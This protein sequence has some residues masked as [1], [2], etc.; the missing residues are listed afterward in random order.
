MLGL[1]FF[2]SK[3]IKIIFLE[4]KLFLR[5]AYQNDLKILKNIYLKQ[6]KKIKKF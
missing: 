5:T 6:R 1:W 2:T 3:Y 4:K